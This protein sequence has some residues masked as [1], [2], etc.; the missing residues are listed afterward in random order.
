MNRLDVALLMRDQGLVP[1]FYDP[2]PET[3]KWVMSACYRAGSRIFEFTNRGE[4]AHLVFQEL[5]AWSKDALP[6]LA[7]GVGS[8]VEEGTAALYMQSGARFIVSPLLN[9]RMA[10]VCNRRKT[11]WIPGCGTASEV[12]RAESLGAEIIKL[13]PASS[14]GGPAFL[15]ALLGPCPWS[16]FMPSGGVSPTRENLASWFE[17]GAFCVG[18]GSKLITGPVIREKDSR[19]LE[20]TTA[21]TL[22]LIREIRATLSGSAPSSPSHA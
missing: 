16:S 10:E 6:G 2:D 15:S 17:A 4:G 13:F 22:S 5:R 8:V 12:A 11:L 20:E 1:L 7:L 9:E 21:Q 19:R 3:C 14:L 18:M